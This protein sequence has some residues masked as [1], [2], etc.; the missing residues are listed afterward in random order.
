MGG[1]EGR[2]RNCRTVKSAEL[3]YVTLIDVLQCV[4]RTFFSNIGSCNC[5][6][7]RK[8]ALFVSVKLN[9]RSSGFESQ[10]VASSLRDPEQRAEVVKANIGFR[11]LKRIRGSSE[12]DEEG[13]KNAYAMVRQLGSFTFFLTISMGDTRWP[14]YKRCLSK[15]VDHK[16]LTLEES[17]DLPFKTVAR[18]VRSDPVTSARYHR[19]RLD[20]ILEILRECPIVWKDRR[21]LVARRVSAERNSSYSYGSVGEKRAGFRHPIR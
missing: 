7:F 2:K 15:V 12:Y 6:R 13:K 21:F 9:L 17:R 10:S 16:D 3:N 14:E 19:F 18:L 11:D 20:E 4:L 5:L 1:V 8:R